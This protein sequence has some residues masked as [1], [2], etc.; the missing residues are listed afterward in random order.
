[1]EP[2]LVG[3]CIIC[4]CPIY[5]IIDEDDRIIYRCDCIHKGANKFCDDM[6]NT[7]VVKD[8]E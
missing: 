3:R 6:N 7:E 5:E 2:I 4:D 8:E 1:M